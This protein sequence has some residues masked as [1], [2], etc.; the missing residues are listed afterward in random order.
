MSVAARVWIA[1]VVLY[2]GFFAWYTSFGGPLRPDEIAHY[3]SVMEAAGQE[4]AEIEKW[5]LFMESDTGDDFAMLNVIDMAD[6]PKPLPG[7]APGETSSEVMAR[8]SEPFLGR[9]LSAAAHP[10]MMGS[11][12][13]TAIDLWGIEGAEVWDTGA[14][15]R[16][17]S[18]RDLM[19]QVDWATTLPDAIHDFKIAALEKTI[20][21][22][23]DPWF[24]LGD[25]R[26]VLAMGLAIV[27]LLVQLG[28]GRRSP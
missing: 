26:L 7:V 14:L 2:A 18:R 5:R 24:Q 9:A 10:V 3:V 22:P 20:A 27:G 4:P 16:Y 13:A 19:V 8:Y 1:L 21:Y 17:R 6:A 23:L 12:A 11:A 28:T 25:P 15:V